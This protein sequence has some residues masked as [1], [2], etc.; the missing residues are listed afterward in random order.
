L[1][2][3]CLAIDLDGLANGCVGI[4]R[5]LRFAVGDRHEAEERQG[6]DDKKFHGLSPLN[7]RREQ[8]GFRE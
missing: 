3:L 1:A 4:T 2:I 7:R 8:P 5:T 6:A